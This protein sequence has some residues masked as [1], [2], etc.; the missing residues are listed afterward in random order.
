MVVLKGADTSEV[1][2]SRVVLLNGVV[3]MSR[4]VEVLLLL[5]LSLYP[6]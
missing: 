4:V 1:L 5:L 6:L 3:D 2:T